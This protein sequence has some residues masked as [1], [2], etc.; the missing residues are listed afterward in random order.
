MLTA[1]RKNYFWPGIR[2]DIVEYLNKCLECQQVKV[3]HRHPGGLMQPITVPKWKWEVISLD[4]I[5]GLPRSKKHNDSIM[6]V[7]D[8]SSKS[9]HFIPMHSTYEMAQIAD[10]SMREIFRLHGIP[11]TVISNRDVNFTSAF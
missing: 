8:R 9:T 10:I 2:R 3:E 5:T 1:I 11:K 6:V 4:F 7:V